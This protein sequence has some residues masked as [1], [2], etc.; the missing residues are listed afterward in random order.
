MPGARPV[1]SENALDFCP[2][3]LRLRIQNGGIHVSLQRN[4]VPDSCPCP[5]NVG[6]PV[7]TTA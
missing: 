7:Q 5:L 4:L 1:V 3:Y 2:D 6:G